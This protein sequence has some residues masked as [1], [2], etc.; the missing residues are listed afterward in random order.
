M[1][2]KSYF[3]KILNYYN[4]STIKELSEKTGIGASTISA[5]NQR[6]SIPAL[7]KATRELGIY[8]EIFSTSAL[9]S[10]MLVDEENDV[11]K[12]RT[13]N[14]GIVLT[15]EFI[16]LSNS[17]GD[18]IFSK[19]KYS[20]KDFNKTIILNFLNVYQKFEKENNLKG[21]LKALADLE[22]E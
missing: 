6:Q 9:D 18:Y 19:T 12:E 7:K 5:W 21:L 11:N 16:I 8:N 22:F 2:F 10:I 4:V 17:A 1:E 20:K 15:P 13:N 14:N 3:E